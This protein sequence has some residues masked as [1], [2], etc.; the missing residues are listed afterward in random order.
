MKRYLMLCG[1]QDKLD[2]LNELKSSLREYLDEAQEEVSIDDYLNGIALLN[3][4]GYAGQGKLACGL[5][6]IH[7][8][9]GW[10]FPWCLYAV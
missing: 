5:M 9:R 2:N 10:N 1:N 4:R 6:T 3:E 8:Q 7:T